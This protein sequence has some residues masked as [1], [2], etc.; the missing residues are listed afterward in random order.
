VNGG[1]H[2]TDVTNASRT[3]LM[4]LE[5]LQWDDE[6]CSFFGIK[7]SC[8]PEIKSS[9]EIYANVAMGMFKDVPIA[10]ILGDQQAALVGQL[11]FQKGQLKNTYG[12]G[13]FMLCNTGK[14]P[15]ISTHGLLTT[16]AYKLGKDA[17]CFYALEGSIA[18]AGSSVQWLRDNLAII[19][20]AKQVG[21]YA[22]QVENNGGVYFVPAFSGIS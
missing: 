10:G 13:C 18:V 22:N 4:N 15:V 1:V 7:K 6:M 20:S 12:T 17:P 21:E 8:L 2:V 5:T 19:Q 14:S 3:M 9:S 11:C 16:P